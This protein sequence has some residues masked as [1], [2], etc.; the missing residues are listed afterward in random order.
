[1]ARKDGFTCNSVMQF[2]AAPSLTVSV[3]YSGVGFD[4]FTGIHFSAVDA[5]TPR[6]ALVASELMI[7]SPKYLTDGTLATVGK[8]NLKTE[9]DA[10][11]CDASATGQNSG[12]SYFRMGQSA[13]YITWSQY[14]LTV[15]GVFV[16]RLKGDF[17]KNFVVLVPATDVV[18]GVL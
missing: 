15:D 12:S 18:E 7:V 13:P 10:K 17:A 14:D 6:C 5:T 1:V 4:A 11:M 8:I 2:A 9:V 3:G 16:G